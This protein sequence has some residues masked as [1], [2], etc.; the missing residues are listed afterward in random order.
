MKEARAHYFATHS[1]DWTH[2]NME[3]LSDIFKELAQEAGLLGE[4]IFKLQWSWEGPEHLKQ[5]NYIFQSQPKGLKFLRAVS[6]KESPKEMG[7]KGIHEPEAL[8][9]FARFTY[10][11]WCGKYRQN[12]GDHHKSPKNGTLQVRSHMQPVLWLSYNYGRH[13]LQTWPCH[14]YRLGHYLQGGHSACPP[15]E[16]A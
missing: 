9:H 11:P 5:A 7:L 2:S 8:R 4:S 1:W 13:S 12:E 3:D 14:L 10:C 15:M 16:S 6:A